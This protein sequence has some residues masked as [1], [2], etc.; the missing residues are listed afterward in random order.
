MPPKPVAPVLASPVSGFKTD[1]T[2][3]DLGWKAVAYGNT[4]EIQIDDSSTF[5]SPNYTYSF[6][7]G[8]SY[9]AGPLAPGKWYWR[10]RAVN[11]AS[12]AGSWSSS[13]YF[14]IYAKFNTQFN[15]AGNFEG[16][17]NHPGASWS[18]GSG[19]LYTAGLSSSWNTSSAS[20]GNATFNDFTYT[21]RI[22]ADYGGGTYNYL[23]TFGGL[24]VRG[25]PT[26]DAYNDW[27]SA[28]YFSVGQTYDSTYG[29]YACYNVFKLVNSYWTSQT[30]G[31][32]YWCTSAYN[33]NNWNELKV[34]ASGSTL[35]FYINN[36]LVWSKSVSG[37][38]SGRVG[39]FSYHRPGYTAPFYV[40]WAV[41]GM[42]V[43]P[44]AS[45][46]VAPGQFPYIPKEG[47]DLFPKGLK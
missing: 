45:R 10:V 30:S 34:Y 13:R 27:Q 2:S 12:V 1:E 7:P 46:T 41:A 8:L 43:L 44:T 11:E 16:W 23:N 24:V 18:V 5:A 33:F 3:L 39:V 4:Y 15:T 21:A 28:Y 40:D 14:T 17:Q 9:T 20:Y 47:E 36:T 29:G 37:P 42:P 25:T 22:K 32:Y 6:L 26:F 38:T 31:G 19:N 35:K